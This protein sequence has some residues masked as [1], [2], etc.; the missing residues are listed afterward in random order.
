MDAVPWISSE[1][2]RKNNGISSRPIDEIQL[3]TTYLRRI[4]MQSMKFFFAVLAS[5]LL[6]NAALANI[7]I[8]FDIV[9]CPSSVDLD[10]VSQPGLLIVNG[11][12][13]NRGLD[14]VEFRVSMSIAG[15]A[16]NS[17]GGLGVYGPQVARCEIE[18]S[19]FSR[20][21]APCEYHVDP[22]E[23]VFLRGIRDLSPPNSLSGSLAMVAYIIEL[24]TYVD[25]KKIK[26]QHCIVNVEGTTGKGIK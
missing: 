19:D 9:D 26:M 13:R 10:A 15:N 16:D 4:E 22:G 17:V 3:T 8:D 25:S 23:E 14:T 1:G 20:S 7:A 12:L 18:G 11:T 21:L 24:E 2:L 6:S 5:A